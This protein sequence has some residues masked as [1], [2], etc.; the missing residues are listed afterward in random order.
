MAETALD[1]LLALSLVGLGASV[2]FTERA[3]R[4]S[5][6]FTISGLVTAVAWVRLGAPDIALA[7]VAVGAGVTGA[8]LLDTAILLVGPADVRVGRRRG[9]AADPARRVAAF[10]G[11]IAVVGG[12]VWA[13]WSLRSR[14]DGLGGS[15]DAVL[16]DTGVDQRVTAVLLSLRTFDTWLEMGVL[17]AAALGMVVAAGLAR[18]ADE[19]SGVDAGVVEERFVRLLTPLLVLVGVYVL[20]R[21]TVAAGGAFQGGAVIGAA[22]ILLWV[23]GHR[24]VGRAAHLPTALLSGGFGAF[25]AVAVA[26]MAVSTTLAVRGTPA[27]VVIVALEVA[28]GF[29]VAYTMLH[30][31]VAGRASDH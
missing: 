31:F 22:A 26:T 2:V 21:G 28:I 16:E 14:L 23:T 20:S 5:V 27:T 9:G 3:V 6:L 29:A 10:L 19:R 1:L 15:V 12:L 25:I 8:L 11:A 18:L 17:L 7:E 4:A 30:L 13:M 24:V